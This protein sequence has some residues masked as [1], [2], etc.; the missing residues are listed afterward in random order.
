VRPAL[1]AA[2]LLA[3]LVVAAA[4]GDDRARGQSGTT[5]T[6]ASTP[7]P[8]PGITGPTLAAAG[9]IACPPSMSP[10]R[11]GCRQADTA[12]VVRGLDPDVVA[13]LGDLQYDRG[14]L[15]NFRRAYDPT[16]GRFKAR[17]RPA[18][19]NHEY[20]TPGGA[21]YFTYW[22]SRAGRRGRGWYS[23]D[24]GTWHVV[25]LNS[26][27]SKV[28]CAPGSVQERWLRADL[29]AHPARCTLA[30]WHH[31]RFSSGLHGN[32]SSVAPLWRALYD[33]RADVILNGHD[34]SYERFAQQTP[35]A[36]ASTNGIVEFV[37]GT[38][39]VNNYPIVR[40]RPNSVIRRS[41]VFGVL[42]L[43]LGEGEY[44]WRF[45]SVPGLTFTDGGTARCH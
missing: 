8:P 24:V 44:G 9:D 43:T 4:C 25:V 12:A 17:T 42:E 34:H 29:R 7:P 39:G 33:A 21:G 20:A 16:W 19:G 13:A 5:T 6:Q 1:A 36:H 10:S 27:C 11:A 23:Y 22:G 26:N 2:A 40:R 32:D 15:S 18:P 14:E 38:G 3:L 31:P 28:G 35:T 37:V 30:Y 45:V 41:F